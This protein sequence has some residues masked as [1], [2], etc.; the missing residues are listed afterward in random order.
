MG[1]GTVRV[2]H[3]WELSGKGRS[4]RRKCWPSFLAH[5]SLGTCSFLSSFSEPWG[6][7]RLPGAWLPPPLPAVHP[8]LVATKQ[9]H[10]A[11]WE[12]AAPVTEP[13]DSSTS[14]LGH[15]LTE[16]PPLQGDAPGIPKSWHT[17]IS[18]GSCCSLAAGWPGLGARGQTQ[19]LSGEDVWSPILSQCDALKETSA[20]GGR[21]HTLGV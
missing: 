16:D 14:R 2:Q 7:S 21:R 12:A 19:A 15:E 18:Q 3:E 10:L 1:K 9:H 20:L 17:P 11:Q 5:A 8:E 6:Q 13:H 4:Y